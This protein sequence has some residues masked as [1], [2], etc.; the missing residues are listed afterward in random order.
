[1]EDSEVLQR[2]VVGPDHITTF[3]TKDTKKQKTGQYQDSNA[4]VVAKQSKM[5]EKPIEGS[6]RIGK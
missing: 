3:L 5:T 1:M 6:K 4:K 2:S